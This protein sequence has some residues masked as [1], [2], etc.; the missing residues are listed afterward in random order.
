[1]NGEYLLSLDPYNFNTV[2]EYLKFY[3]AEM[4]KRINEENEQKKDRRNKSKN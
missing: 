3:D 4:Y 1:M 2:E